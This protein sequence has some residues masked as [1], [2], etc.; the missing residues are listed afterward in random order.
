MN[1]STADE[2]KDGSCTVWSDEMKVVLHHL[3]D[4]GDAE[5]LID[6]L[7]NSQNALETNT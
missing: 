1:L 3:V 5:G 4:Q 7:G 6:T 2:Q